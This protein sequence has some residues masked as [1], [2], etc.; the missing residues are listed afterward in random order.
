M[1]S[2]VKRPTGHHHGDLR[3]VLEE[4]A[5]ELVSER[6]AKGFSLAEVCRR[7][8]VSVAAPYKHFADRDE[9]LAVIAR[10]G[11]E[12]QR[13]RYLH[14]MESNLEPVAQLAAFADA[15]VQFAAQERALFEIMFAA[16][17]DKTRYPE[18]AEAGAA[19]FAVLDEPARQ[20]RGSHAAARGL[21]LD[22][23][24][25]AHGWATF[26]VEGV[27]ADEADPLATARKHASLAARALVA[28][29]AGM[30]RRSTGSARP[31][32]PR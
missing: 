20:L 12:E 24:A 3:P 14:A 6:G 18:L 8:G 26:L 31:R 25:A 28:A 1:S 21:I 5:L 10:R 23:A 22:V 15:Y 16:G 17:L 29:D 7:A 2:S 19:L 27:L 32:N 9:L 11:Y 30:R 13:R 4:A